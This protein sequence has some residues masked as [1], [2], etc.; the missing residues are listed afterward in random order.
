MLFRR[1]GGVMRRYG[2]SVRFTGTTY[3]E[4]D[5]PNG[6]DP[7]DYAIDIASPKDVSDWECEIDDVDEVD[8]NE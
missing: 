6:E 4:V 7:E 3:V 2:V 1:N 8:P 5:V